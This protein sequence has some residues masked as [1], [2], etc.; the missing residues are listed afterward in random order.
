MVVEM[1]M[2]KDDGPEAATFNHH[3]TWGS[4]KH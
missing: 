4:K 3:G 1:V 2:T